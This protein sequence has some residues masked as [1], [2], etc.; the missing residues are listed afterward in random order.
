MATGSITRRWGCDECK[1]FTPESL[2][3]AVVACPEG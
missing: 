2:E 1:Y 3:M